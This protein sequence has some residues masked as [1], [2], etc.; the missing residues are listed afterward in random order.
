VAH[1]NALYRASAVILPRRAQEVAG[2]LCPG[3]VAYHRRVTGSCSDRVSSGGG[4]QAGSHQAQA[5]WRTTQPPGLPAWSNAGG[6][7]FD[8]ERSAGHVPRP[9][10][11]PATGARLLAIGELLSSTGWR[12]IQ[13]GAISEP[14]WMGSDV[15]D[16]MSYVQDMPTIRGLA[17]DLG[18]EA[19][20]SQVLD[21]IAEQYAAR[22]R[23]G[24]VWVRAAAWLVTA[25]RP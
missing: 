8:E 15:A 25:R 4:C 22:Q 13:I 24:G 19:L 21:S 2:T 17:T 6:W 23:P 16:V 11:S 7:L 1:H 14:A 3:P 10:N 18:D 12:D 5:A 20:T 9:S